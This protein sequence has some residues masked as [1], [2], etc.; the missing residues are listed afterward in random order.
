MRKMLF[1]VLLLL[2][3]IRSCNWIPFTF[4]SQKA[5]PFSKLS[6][7]LLTVVF[8]HFY[9]REVRAGENIAGLG[10]SPR[11]CT[12]WIWEGDPLLSARRCP[13]WQRATLLNQQNQKT[14][15]KCLREPTNI[16]CL[17][18]KI[19]CLVQTYAIIYFK[20]FQFISTL[21]YKISTHRL[22]YEFRCH[23]N[24]TNLYLII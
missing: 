8:F 21:Y 6:N 5:K 14:N 16:Y 19:I 4:I 20:R 22:R 23:T 11:S 15:R 2:F 10:G 17:P 7:H 1:T 24:R 3:S 18:T 12:N 13:N 9:M